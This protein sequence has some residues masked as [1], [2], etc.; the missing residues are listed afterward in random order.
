MRVFVICALH[1]Y[2]HDIIA[3]RKFIGVNKE[4][5]EQIFGFGDFA[6]RVR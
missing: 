6:R 5:T 4:V 3:D 2:H 1:K